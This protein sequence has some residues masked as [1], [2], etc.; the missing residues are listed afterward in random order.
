[1]G[2]VAVIGT[3]YALHRQSFCI[4][5]WRFTSD[6][7]KIDAAAFEAFQTNN[8]RNVNP[9]VGSPIPY[10]TVEEFRLL[11][12]DCCQI[13]TNDERRRWRGSPDFLNVLFGLQTDIVRVRFLERFPKEDQA[14]QTR[15]KLLM[16]P[17]SSCGEVVVD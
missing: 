4:S 12:P 16:I 17:V 3:I 2:A 6:E 8:A 11:N 15:E 13:A 10:A 5:E 1:V 14:H 7:E 9:S